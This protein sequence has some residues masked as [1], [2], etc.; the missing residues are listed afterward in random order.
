MQSAFR[1]RAA[2]TLRGT[3]LASTLA[4][5]SMLAFSAVPVWADVPMEGYADLVEKVT[6]SVVFIEVTTKADPAMAQA[7]ASPFDGFMK[8]FGAPDQ[9]PGQNFRQNPNQQPDSGP[10]HALGSGFIVSADGEIVTNNHVV[11]GA[12]AIKVRLEDG[13]EFAA[14]VVGY[15]LLF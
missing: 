10:M 11:D 9:G 8:R 4:A 7:N 5:T 14:H 13:R 1:N 3:L 2:I 12:T 6:P 15:S